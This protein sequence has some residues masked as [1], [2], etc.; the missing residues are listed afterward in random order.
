MKKTL[1]V[2]K[3]EGFIEIIE[4]LSEFSKDSPVNIKKPSFILII[5]PDL[6]MGLNPSKYIFF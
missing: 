4:R 3:D 5:S 6:I 1:N 2:S